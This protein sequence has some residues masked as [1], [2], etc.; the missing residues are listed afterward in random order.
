MF[1]NV[2]FVAKSMDIEI[3]HT[4]FSSLKAVQSRVL[5]VCNIYDN[6]G[7]LLSCFLSYK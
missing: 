2:L 5:K 3:V 7:E 4:H 6:L 1:K